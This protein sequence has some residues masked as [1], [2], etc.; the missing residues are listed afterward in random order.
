MKINYDLRT[1]NGFGGIS[2]YKRNIAK[3]L[4]KL[5]EATVIGCYNKARGL[6]KNDYKWFDGDLVESIIPDRFMYKTRMLNGIYYETIMHSPA[7]INYFG[8]YLLPNAKFK[9]PTISTIHDIILLKTD[10]ESTEVVERHKMVLKETIKKSSAIFTVSNSSKM[11]LCDIFNLKPENVHIVHN[12]ID[13]CKYTDIIEEKKPEIRN[14]YALPSKYIIY[15]GGY[16]KHKNIESLLYAY[17]MLPIRI[18]NEISIVVTNTSNELKRLASELKIENNV[19]FTGFV[20]EE[21]KPYLYGMAE[22]SY[23][24]SFYEGFGVPVL[25]AQASRIPVLTSNISSMP[26]A[27]GGAA[28]LVDPNSVSEIRDAILEGLENA[29]LRSKLIEQGFINAQKYTWKESAKE[30]FDAITNLR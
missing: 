10:V 12:G 11:D 18:K 22:L 15:L 7:D 16:R 17:S 3:E 8:T 4:V 30:L 28:L 9:A 27:S 25:E 14:K 20:D 5:D 24:A 2:S 21:D 6:S 19:C 26:E 23:Y 29:N 1:A 13:I